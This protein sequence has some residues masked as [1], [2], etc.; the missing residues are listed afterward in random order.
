MFDRELIEYHISPERMIF[1]KSYIKK[2]IGKIIFLLISLAITLIGVPSLIDLY[3]QNSYGKDAVY[4]I[5]GNATMIPILLCLILMGI[6]FRLYSPDGIYGLSAKEGKGSKAVCS[7][8][9]KKL[10]AATAACLAAA[11]IIISM[12][13]Y[14]KFTLDGVESH[15]FFRVQNYEWE[16]A[17]YY[18]L[19]A[20]IH[21]MLV[22]E[23]VM[24]DGTR[25]GCLGGS[26]RAVEYESVALE[27]RFGEDYAA[28]YVIWMAKTLKEHGKNLRMEEVENLK[29]KLDAEYW[30][31]VADEIV[32]EEE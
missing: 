8:E 12:F 32:K 3:Y 19:K 10:I 26:F 29:Q 7:S 2:V 18:T 16:D 11:G 31:A 20:D 22:F 23:I 28:E 27:E 14:E 13:W 9:K 30:R 4:L 5:T 21:G 1:M 15:H 24:M 17:E 25:H 6:L